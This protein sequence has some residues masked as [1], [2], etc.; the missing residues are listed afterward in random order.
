M[1][2]VQGMVRKPCKPGVLFLS[3]SHG[4]LQGSA[5]LRWPFSGQPA[6][7]CLS[8][9]FLPSAILRGAYPT[10]KLNLA[11]L[12]VEN[13]KQVRGQGQGEADLTKNQI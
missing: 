2:C 10:N 9:S 8:Q 13:T 5:R 7:Q 11:M 12:F 6:T 1:D 3:S 4:L